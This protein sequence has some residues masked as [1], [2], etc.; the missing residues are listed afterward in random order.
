MKT[1]VLSLLLICSLLA[2]VFAQSSSTISLELFAGSNDWWVAVAV[3]NANVDTSSVT[4][5]D[6]SSASYPMTL[7]NGWG[8]WSTSSSGAAFQFPLSFELTSADGSTVTASNIISLGDSQVDTGVQ[9]GSDSTVSTSSEADSSDVGSVEAQPGASSNSHISHAYPTTAPKSKATVA[10]TTASKSKSKATTAPTTASKTKATVAPTTASK[11]KATVAPTTGSSSG[12]STGCSAPMKLLVPLYSYPGSDWDTVIASAKVVSTVAVINP[13]SGPGDGPDSTYN[14]YMTKMHSA[15]VEMIGYVHTSYGARAI[16]DVKADIAAYA[17][18]FPL[19]VGIFIDEAATS[20]SEV[21]Y[22]MEIY[23]YIMS[24]PGWKYDVIN[25]GTVPSSGY[26]AAS[27][28]IVTY[29]S[30]ASGFASSSNPSFATCTDKNQFVMISYAGSTVA[31][32]ESA[33]LAAKTKS[34][35][36]WAFV[37]SGTLSGDTYGALPSYYATQ[38]SYIASLN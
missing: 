33:I 34:Y 22:Y 38:A 16:A 21:S 5:I 2:S 26:L 7:N 31:A 30:N 1:T 3:S 8:F 14:T 6:A 10:P 18:E 17:S 36:G 15:G 20:S 4:L 35:Y 27:T 25:P 12:S 11:T 24:F 32:M 19:V 28:Q 29:E 23:E 9:Y 37:T 13:D